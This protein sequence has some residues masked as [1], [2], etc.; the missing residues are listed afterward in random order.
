MIPSSCSSIFGSKDCNYDLSHSWP[1]LVIKNNTKNKRTSTTL[2][3]G[4]V[5]DK[6]GYQPG[7][8]AKAAAIDVIT[9]P[10]QAIFVGFYILGGTH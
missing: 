3:S 8:V 1:R 10:F 2:L 9:F 4:R 7:D 5:G 6:K